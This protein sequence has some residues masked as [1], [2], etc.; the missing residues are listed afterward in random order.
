M[1]CLPKLNFAIVDVRD[2]AAAHIKAM[3]TT[4]ASGKTTNQLPR[5]KLNNKVSEQVRHKPTCTVTEKS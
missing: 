4:E 1:M 3:T 2:V 5:G